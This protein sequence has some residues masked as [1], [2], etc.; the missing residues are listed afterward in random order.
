MMRLKANLHHCW[1]SWKVNPDHVGKKNLSY[2]VVECLVSLKPGTGNSVPSGRELVGFLCV[3][4]R[5]KT[6]CMWYGH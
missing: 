5:G 2:H 3:R 4:A 6:A 1:V